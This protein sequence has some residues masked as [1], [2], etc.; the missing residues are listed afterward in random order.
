M[1]NQIEFQNQIIEKLHAVECNGVG[2]HRKR[3]RGAVITKAIEELQGRG[4]SEPMARQIAQDARD[5]WA[6]QTAC[7]EDE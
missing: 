5:V 2:L 7:G 1:F 4:Y 3:S 6:L